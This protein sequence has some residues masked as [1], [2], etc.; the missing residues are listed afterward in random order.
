LT[1]QGPER[2]RSYVRIV[3][4]APRV[5][6]I[7][8]DSRWRVLR[9]GCCIGC[10]QPANAAGRNLS[11]SKP[12]LAT[13]SL[14]TRKKSDFQ[15]TS[16]EI[17]S[18]KIPNQPRCV[19]QTERMQLRSHR[20]ARS[21]SIRGCHNIDTVNVGISIGSAKQHMPRRS[22]SVWRSGTVAT[23]CVSRAKATAAENPLTAVPIRRSRASDVSAVSALETV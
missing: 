14:P 6:L 3:P 19:P 16:D 22:P 8:W 15:C 5:W 10:V 4:G 9:A 17:L 13:I 18:E 20:C 21:P 12:M 23:S 7:C 2:Q 1:E 11:A